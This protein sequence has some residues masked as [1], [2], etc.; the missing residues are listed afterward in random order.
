MFETENE[1]IEFARLKL[2]KD[3]QAKKIFYRSVS[4]PTLSKSRA[5]GKISFQTANERTR[6]V[7]NSGPKK[8]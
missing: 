6:I 5:F 7:L 3:Y 4:I 2:G 8:K 1:V